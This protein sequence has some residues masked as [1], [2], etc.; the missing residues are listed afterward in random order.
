MASM[1]DVDRLPDN[2]LFLV[3]EAGRE[4]QLVQLLIAFEQARGFGHH[5][6]QI[7]DHAEG[8]LRCAEQ[9]LAFFRSCLRS[10]ECQFGH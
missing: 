3:I 9:R 1:L 10:V 2:R 7:G 5:R 6:V 8:L 4:K